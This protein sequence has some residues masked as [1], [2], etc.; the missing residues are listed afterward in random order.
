VRGERTRERLLTAAVEL[1]GSRGFEATSMKDLAAAAGVQAPAI[2]NHF[3]SK[4]DILIAATTWALED[5]YNAVVAADDQGSPTAERLKQLVRRHVLYQLE[6]DRLARANDLLLSME[7]LEKVMPASA[8]EHVWALLR[9][10][11]DLTTDLV[12]ELTVTTTGLP[13]ARVSA[14][15]IQSMCD[16]VL[17]WYKPHGPLSPDEVADAFWILVQGMLR[18]SLDDTDPVLPSTRSRASATK[19]ARNR[20]SSK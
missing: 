17:S 2:Y 8:H 15:A 6:H 10:Y 11:L 4:E 7:A 20:A 14:L 3:Q 16:R 13:P 9:Q 12:T 5:F 19:T 1:F 18:I